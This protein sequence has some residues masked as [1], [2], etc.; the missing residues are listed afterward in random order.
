[1][2]KAVIGVSLARS[3]CDRSHQPVVEVL[4]QVQL[5]GLEV[6]VRLHGRPIGAG[7]L[8]LRN[9]SMSQPKNSRVEQATSSARTNVARATGVVLHKSVS[10]IG[11]AYQH[12]TGVS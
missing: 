8:S 12:F 3:N 9:Q 5:S 7:N 11:F 1:V 4:D 2:S 6:R 10:I